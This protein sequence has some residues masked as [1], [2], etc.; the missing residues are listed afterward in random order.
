MQATAEEAAAKASAIAAGTPSEP[1]ESPSE[2]A[3]SDRIEDS[4]KEGATKA[5]Q[6]IA[7]QESSQCAEFLA[8]SILDMQSIYGMICLGSVAFQT[9][10]FVK[11]AILKR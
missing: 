11:M 2:L 10:L 6:P 4:D 1:I 5:P 8:V 9:T 3:P 7:G